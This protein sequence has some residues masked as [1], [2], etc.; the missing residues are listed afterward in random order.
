MREDSTLRRSQGREWRT[1]SR[2][3]WRQVSESHQRSFRRCWIWIRRC[4]EIV[5]EILRRISARKASCIYRLR[6][7]T[8]DVVARSILPK[9]DTR[10][11]VR[12]SQFSTQHSFRNIT[13][14]M[15]IQLSEHG[16]ELSRIRNGD[17]WKS[18]LSI[19]IF[20]FIARCTMK[21][22]PFLAERKQNE[23]KYSLFFFKT[24]ICVWRI[25]YESY[26]VVDVHFI[27]ERHW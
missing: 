27:L 12:L 16:A 18:A 20:M 26:E 4:V 24:L 11:N 10:I 14:P 1:F 8:H 9:G 3:Q 13:P 2:A 7:K 5:E 23:R 17:G 25:W 21:E 22:P 6:L 15:K 19:L